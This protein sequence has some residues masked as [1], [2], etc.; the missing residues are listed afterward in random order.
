MHWRLCTDLQ[1]I[2]NPTL[3]APYGC[4]LDFALTPL[5]TRLISSLHSLCYVIM[6]FSCSYRW[7]YWHRTQPSTAPQGGLKGQLVE[8]LQ[9]QKS[10]VLKCFAGLRQQPHRNEHPMDCKKG[11]RTRAH[12]TI[13]SNGNHAVALRWH[14]SVFPSFLYAL[15]QILT[16]LKLHSLQA[17]F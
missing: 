3:Q 1:L 16:A 15:I 5:W 6:R 10:P 13:R 12:R 11:I 14:G 8:L 2:S 7:S 4:N 9:G 17:S